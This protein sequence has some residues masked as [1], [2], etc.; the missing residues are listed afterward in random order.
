MIAKNIAKV[1]K[2]YEYGV[3][4]LGYRIQPGCAHLKR[5]TVNRAL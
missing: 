1:T 5:R 4:T 3:E 2:I